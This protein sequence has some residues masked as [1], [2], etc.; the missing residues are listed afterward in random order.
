MCMGKILF[1]SFAIVAAFIMTAST[2][3]SSDK[4]VTVTVDRAKV[5]RIEEEAATVIVG[6]PF[7]AD[8]AMHDRFT[9]V[10]TGKSYG[11]TNLVILDDNG[12]PIID[13]IIVV[14]SA[15]D[16]VVSVT[17]NAAR[18]TYSCQP[19]CEPV[20]QLGD[21]PGAFDAFA[22]QATKRNQLAE[23]AAGASQ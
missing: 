2:A 16:N 13:E 3:N 17:R 4:Q 9:V 14:R 21:N 11:S 18:Q 10:I 22:E 6:N 20:L 23:Q 15:K 7:I 19:V 8:V 5:F 1:G 12:E